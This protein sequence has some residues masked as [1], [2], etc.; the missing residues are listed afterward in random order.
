MEKGL[1][2][3][4]GAVNLPPA[5]AEVTAKARRSRGSMRRSPS[6]PRSTGASRPKGNPTRRR[7]RRRG[8]LATAKTTTD[9]YVV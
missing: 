9:F 1:S 4:E 6:G 8:G 2:A 7:A 3:R 5:T